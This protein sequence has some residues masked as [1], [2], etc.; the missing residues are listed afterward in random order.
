[1]YQQLKTLV[2]PI[3]TAFLILG[4]LLL[5]LQPTTALADSFNDNVIL[6]YDPSSAVATCDLTGTGTGVGGGDVITPKGFS[7]GTEPLKRRVNLVKALMAD[8]GLTA[9]QASGIVGNFM[10]ES[11]GTSTVAKTLPPDVN[12]GTTTGAPPKFSGGYGW[13]QWTGSRQRTFIDYAIHLGHMASASVRANDA[14][15]YGYLQHELRTGYKSTITQ[16]KT[17]TTP[18]DAAVSFEATFE[19]AGVPALTERKAG[20]RQVFTEYNGGGSAV[21]GTPGAGDQ[22]GC[23]PS[24]SAAG[25]ATIVGNYA[26]PL[27]GT[28]KTVKNPG[29]FKNGTADRGGHPYTSYDILANEGTPVVAFLSGRVIRVS[30]DRCPGRLISVYN[31]ESNL[32]I[33][34]L[35]LS[36]SGHVADKAAI[37][38]GQRIGTVGAASPN[39]CGTAHLHIDAARGEGRPGCSR[40]DCPAANASKFVDIGPQLFT[41]FQKLP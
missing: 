39:G 33:S 7:L 15:D 24:G 30:K 9:A 23:A 10:H 14:A 41:T 25:G 28:K 5:A 3:K 35:H 26:F 12:Q 22:S 36:T 32:T 2:R 38:V 27:A 4:C 18:E 29:M 37:A 31:K 17:K 8:F 40:L 13:A 20:A 16:L 1:M 19:R 6:F 34:Y 11:A 21:P